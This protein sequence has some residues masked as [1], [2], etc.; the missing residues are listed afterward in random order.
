MCPLI[1]LSAKMCRTAADLKIWAKSLFSDAKIQLHL[2]CEVV[3]RLDVAQE[4]RS[5]SHSEFLLRKQLKQRILGLT[6]VEHA[7]KRQASRI[8]SLKAGDARTAFF[9]AKII[10]RR[11]IIIHSLYTDTTTVTA[12]ENKAAAA[13]SHFTSLLGAK[14]TRGCSTN[15]DCI[16]M[17]TI[18]NEGLDNPFSE[19]E[20]WAALVMASP[21][22]RAPGPDGFSGSFFRS[23]WG[24]IKDNVMAVFEHFYRLVGGNFVDLNTVIALIPKKDG[25]R[26]MSD[27]RPI[28]LIHSIAKLI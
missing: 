12:H 7:R 16:D 1:R 9:Q 17:P 15:W 13:H 11:K 3:L 20:V 2:A 27:S 18:P 10:S 21:A 28:S 23:C 14:K 19:P 4:K 5:Q 22:E 25:A 6:A 24:T 26:K 8:T